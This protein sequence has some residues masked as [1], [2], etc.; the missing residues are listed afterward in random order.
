MK[1]LVAL[2]ALAA[3]LVTALPAGS[4][5][6][7]VGPER[8]EITLEENSS[9]AALVDYLAKGDVT[10]KMEDYGNFEKTGELGTRLPVNDERITTVP[11]DVILYL[12]RKIVLYYDENTWNFTRLGRIQGKSQAELKRILGRVSVSVRFSLE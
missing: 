2:A 4:I 9:A 5:Y 10:V 7:Y 8:L 3:V 6:A 12:G 1:K 11:G